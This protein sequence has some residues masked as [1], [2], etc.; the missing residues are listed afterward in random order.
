MKNWHE[1]AIEM[2]CKGMT[3]REISNQLGVH[4]EAVRTCLKRWKKSGK[5]GVTK[6][7][8]LQNQV[9][10]N[11]EFELKEGN[12]RVTYNSYDDSYTYEM[13][14]KVPKGEVITPEK[15]LSINNLDTNEWQVKHFT[16]NNWQGFTNNDG[17][18][19]KVDLYQ[20]KL[21]VCPKG[22]EDISFADIEKYFADRKFEQIKAPTPK[23]FE[24]DS[25]ILEVD[26][27]DLHSGLLSYRK[28]TGDDFDVNIACER[29]IETCKE[30]VYRCQGKKFEKIIIASLG[31]IIHIDNNQGTTTKGTPQDVD[32]RVERIVELTF[33]AFIT[34]INML[35]EIAPIDFIYVK[36]NH[37]ELVGCL[38]AFALKQAYNENPN[39][40]FDITPN[41]QKAVMI[42]DCLVGYEHNSGS[43][44][45]QSDWLV[46]DFRHLFGK[47]KYAELHAGHLHSQI[48]NE[49]ANG[50]VTRN[51]PALCGTSSWEKISHYR[52]YR[53]MI[54]F[55]WSKKDLLKEQWYLF[56]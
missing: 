20:V 53:A 42:Y 31:D 38:F 11:A 37:D 30:L 3:P 7:M 41:P 5:S 12:K 36:G 21:Q 43:K 1:E 15:V 45:N 29:L 52:A 46:N 27:T 2:Y 35:L 39:I 47:C 10:Q 16:I 44:A 48:T 4:Y 54:C 18:I 17:E 40:T 34:C 14:I 26:I 6:E 56:I 24:K 9:Q 51:L 28:E 23:Q 25:E 13:A 8:Q 19:D 32:G 55:V 50:V 33:N 49:K 22:K